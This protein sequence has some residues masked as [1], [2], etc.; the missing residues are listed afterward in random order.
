MGLVGNVLILAI[1]PSLDWDSYPWGYMGLVGNSEKYCRL[2]DS[3]HYS[4]PMGLHGTSWKRTLASQLPER[5]IFGP[6][7]WGYM[8]LVGNELL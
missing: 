6:Y 4:L 2:G 8:G 7:P 1:Q 3:L 5:D